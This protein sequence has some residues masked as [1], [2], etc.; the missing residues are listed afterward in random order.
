MLT[1]LLKTSTV[2][3]EVSLFFFFTAKCTLLLS[4]TWASFSLSNNEQKTFSVYLIRAILTNI[5]LKLCLGKGNQ[6]LEL[7]KTPKFFFLYFSFTHYTNDLV[8][9]SSYGIYSIEQE[10]NEWKWKCGLFGLGRKMKCKQLIVS[11]SD[12]HVHSLLT[13]VL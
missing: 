5:V 7:L 13:L 12:F 1:R 2:K 9:Q 4:G 6:A 8:H 3:V 10:S 11:K